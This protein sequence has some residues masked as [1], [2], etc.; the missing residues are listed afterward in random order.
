MDK[1]IN[2]FSI[3]LFFWQSLVFILL[4][5]V[6][7]K[8]AWK[9]ILNAVNEREQSIED[10][11]KEAEKARLEMQSLQQ[12][13]EA[14]LKEAREER[15]RIL[16]EARDM[17]NKMITEAKEAA[18]TEA[19]KAIVSAKAAIEAEK[20]AAIAELKNQ[21]ASLSIDVAE[22]ILGQELSAENKQTAMIGK[23]IE[24]VKFN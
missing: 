3:G 18:A 9:P 6:L 20:T 2:D 1:L 7:K 24:D 22:K 19:D 17:K 15:E 11:L 8:Y 5:F 14:I 12:S 13:N 23:I 16:K 21:A 10:A 4:I